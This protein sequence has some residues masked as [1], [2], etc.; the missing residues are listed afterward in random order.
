MTTVISFVLGMMFG[1]M[2]GIIMAAVL[3]A[4]RE[5]KDEIMKITDEKFEKLM[6]MVKEGYEVHIEN[7]PEGTRI[8]IMPWKPFE[9]KCPFDSCSERGAKMEVDE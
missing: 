2:V 9:Y 1:G 3:M 8:E 5:E 7:T 6:Q 4:S